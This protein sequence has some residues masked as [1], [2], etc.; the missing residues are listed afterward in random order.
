MNSIRVGTIFV[1]VIFLAGGA[2]FLLLNEQK[3]QSTEERIEIVPDNEILSETVTFYSASDTEA[4]VVF[5]IT[6]ATVT[7]SDLGTIILKQVD[8]PTGGLYTDANETVTL[9]DTGD[10]ITIWRGGDVLFE[11]N[12]EKQ[13]V[14]PLD[15]KLVE[16]VWV[17]E[18]TEMSDGSVTSPK[19]NNTF[20]LTFSIDGQ[21][22]GTTDC[23]NFGG[24]YVS[25][26]ENSLVFGPFMSTQM[27][28][29]DSQENEFVSALREV[30]AFEVTN[31]EK[32]VL[33]MKGERGAITFH[34]Q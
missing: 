23:N 32:L 8:S 16:S 22:S 14:A 28:C 4:T 10:T 20:S 9:W 27:Y 2:Y 1:F 25:Q 18:K 34:A 19:G 15:M 21:V 24:T 5:S 11:G 6:D 3:V 13:E 12:D 29:N 17:W 7:T 30:E 33:Y 26:L 31:E